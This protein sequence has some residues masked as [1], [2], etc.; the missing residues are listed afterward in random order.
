MHDSRQVPPGGRDTFCFISRWRAHRG[1]GPGR[2]AA[3]L[4][5]RLVY[6]EEV[7]AQIDWSLLVK[8]SALFAVLAGGEK[9]SLHKQLFGFA[10]RFHLAKIPVLSLASVLLSN[11]VSNVPSVRLFKPVIQRL[12]SAQEAWLALSMSATLAGSIGLPLPVITAGAAVLWLEW[13]KP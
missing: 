1:V 2:R 7:Y 12:P 6:P 4:I 8:F 9:T 5:T 3:L 13:L 10:A 11:A